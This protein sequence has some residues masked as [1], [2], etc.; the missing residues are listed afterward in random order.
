MCVAHC[1]DC[2]C[3][4][5]DVHLLFVDGITECHVRLQLVQLDPVHWPREV[6]RGGW[7]LV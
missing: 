7:R 5:C 4:S 3:L 2:V 1:C 6:G